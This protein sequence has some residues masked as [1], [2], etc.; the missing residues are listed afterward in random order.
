MKLISALYCMGSL[1]FLA[2][3]VLMLIRNWK[4]NP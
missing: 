3:S 4:A 2:G 1:L